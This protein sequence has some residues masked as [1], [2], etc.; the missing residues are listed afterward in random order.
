MIAEKVAVLYRGGPETDARLHLAVG[1]HPYAPLC[2]GQNYR[3]ILRSA[4]PYSVSL[5]DP[6]T[7]PLLKAVN[8]LAEQL[9]IR[10][11]AQVLTD[12]QRT[13]LCRRC[14]SDLA[15]ETTKGP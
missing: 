6:A 15:P 14:A 1:D 4:Y 5:L 10:S 11:M 7:V 2:A 9:A 8:G 13:R 3:E 12:T